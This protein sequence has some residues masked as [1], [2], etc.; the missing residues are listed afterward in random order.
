MKSE[1]LRIESTP[2]PSSGAERLRA[3]GLKVT[4]PRLAILAFLEQERTHP[5]AEAIFEAL[6][7]EH[8]S[9]SL[10]TVYKTLAVFIRAGLCR[11]VKGEGVLLRVDGTLVP[12]DHAVCRACGAIFDVTAGAVEH[13]IPPARLPGGLTVR[14]LRVEYD[15]VCAAC[16]PAA[17]RSRRRERYERGGVAAK[18]VS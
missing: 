5:S 2:D 17:G 11:H 14:G 3:T 18:A 15:V 12:H 9:L 10:S 1:L 8:P 7:T 4:G 6:R 13:P 16:G